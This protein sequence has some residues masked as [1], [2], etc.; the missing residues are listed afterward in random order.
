MPKTKEVIADCNKEL[1]V[2]KETMTDTYYGRP[3]CS[4]GLGLLGLAKALLVI[5]ELFYNKENRDG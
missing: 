2:L 4:T 3:A 1:Q 5:G